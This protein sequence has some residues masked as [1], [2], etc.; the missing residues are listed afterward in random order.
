MNLDQD[1]LRTLATGLGAV[2]IGIGGLLAL[3]PRLSGRVFGLP[4]GRQ[5]TAPVMFRA[6]GVRDVVINVGL[7]SAAQHGGNYR[8]WLLARALSDAGDV[9]AVLLAALAG[10]RDPRTYGLG[11]VALVHTAVDLLLWRAARRAARPGAL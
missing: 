2:S 4:V 5:P 1:R 10:A 9:L 11:A 6:A 8:P 7:I 3:T